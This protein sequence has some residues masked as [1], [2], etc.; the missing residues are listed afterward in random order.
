MQ[1]SGSAYPQDTKYPDFFN[2]KLLSRTRKAGALPASAF[3]SR[4]LWEFGL[5]CDLL[6]LY[7]KS[8]NRR[9]FQ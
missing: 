4:K 6:S 5:F 1:S 9:K 7:V 8:F 3:P 2:I